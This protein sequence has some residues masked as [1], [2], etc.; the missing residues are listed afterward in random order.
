MNRLGIFGETLACIHLLFHGYKIVERN[1]HSRF[2]EIDIIAKK[3]GVTVFVEVKA[4]SGNMLADPAYAVDNFKQQKL[5]KTAYH[6]MSRGGDDD[7]RFDV[8][9][10]KRQGIRLSVRHIEDAFQI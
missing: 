5:I 3:H 10:I 1:F 2:G 7:F 8:V 9:E 4:R 6:Y